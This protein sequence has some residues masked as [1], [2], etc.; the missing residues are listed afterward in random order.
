MLGRMEKGAIVRTGGQILVD[1]L[2]D[3]GVDVVFGVPGESYLAALDAMYERRNAIRY[4]T[5]RQEGGAAFAAAAYSDLTGGPGVCFVTRGPGV[6]NASIAL[7][8]AWQGSTPLILLIGQIKRAFRDRD[9]FQEIDYRQFL[10]STVKWVAEVDDAARLPEYLHRAF[11]VAMS[12][13]PGPVALALPEDMLFDV[14][15]TQDLPAAERTVVPPSNENIEQIG[16]MLTEA[17]KPLLLLGGTCWTRDGHEAI[18]RFAEAH[19]LPVAVAFRRQG[20][21]P[22]DH[23]NFVGSLGFGGIPE[24]NAYAAES[25]LILA[26]GARLNDP[27]TLKFSILPAPIPDCRIVHVHPD[28]AELGRLYRTDLAIPADPSAAAVAMAQSRADRVHGSALATARERYVAA[29][30]LRPQPGPVDMADVMEV[31]NR[32]L[33]AGTS[34][35]TGAGNAS[36]WPNIYYRCRKFLGA[37][38]PVSG[39]MGM[40]VPAAIAAKIARPDAPAV[41]MGGDGDFLMNGQEL[42]TAVQFGLNPIFIILDNEKYG[43]IRGNQEGRYPGRTLGTS[44]RSPDFAGMAD[45]YGALGI[46]VEDTE[47][48]EPA[49]E[50]AIASSRATVIH[51]RVGHANLGPNHSLNQGEEL[52]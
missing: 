50:K 29:R 13:R 20:L 1:G 9:A 27:T 35:T 51:L 30:T 3:N 45:C 48:F 36:D 22:G 11:R 47:Q 41:Y 32:I 19:Q 17:N 15:G 6:S 23:P 2:V 8:T 52:V 38:G 18:I 43:T 5:M 40:G 24:P 25:D 12:G 28:P 31:M 46:L 21:F 39:A 33:P 49:L 34:V 16:Q 10:G 4:I 42:A 14:A 7:H 26:I 44:L 37:A